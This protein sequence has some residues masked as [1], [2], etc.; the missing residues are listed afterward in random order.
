[1]EQIRT[2][3]RIGTLDLSVYV[4]RALSRTNDLDWAFKELTALVD[5]YAE[6]IRHGGHAYLEA[7]REAV[8]GRR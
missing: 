5:D 3:S 7:V 8:E 1:M 2:P 4:E 6:H